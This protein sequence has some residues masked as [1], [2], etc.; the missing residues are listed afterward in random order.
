M[1]IVST[2]KTSSKTNYSSENQIDLERSL[3]QT[4]NLTRNGFRWAPQLWGEEIITYS[5]VWQ[6]FVLF[7]E[8]IDWIEERNV[9]FGYQLYIM[10]G[11]PPPK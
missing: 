5:I 6:G 1:C 9:W 10:C 3:K 7:G 2:D 4:I 11:S 8:E